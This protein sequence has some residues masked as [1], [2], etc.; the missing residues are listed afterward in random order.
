MKS[1]SVLA[2]HLMLLINLGCDSFPKRPDGHVY[3]LNTVAGE[4]YQMSVPRST[5]DDFKYTG[6]DIPLD[7]ADKYFCVSPE[8]MIRLQF[9]MSD[10][11]KYAEEKCK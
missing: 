9:W 3:Q 6:K 4:A 8:Y 11:V 7:S 1:L 10:V 5:N 2:L